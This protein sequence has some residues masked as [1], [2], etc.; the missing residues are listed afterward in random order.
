MTTPALHPTA[1]AV[2]AVDGGNSKADVCLIAA[3]GRLLSS[4]RGP[5]VSHQAVG[6]E[7]GMRRLDEL[8]RQVA[9]E[10]GQDAERGPVAPIGVYALAG[11]DY[12][13]DVR[14]LEAAIG[15]LGATER[16]VV[17]NDCLAALRAGAPRGWG[18]ALI[19]GEGVNAVG[20]APDGRSSGF[21]ALGEISGDWGG[22]YG[23][24]MTGH[25]AAVRAED[26][27][28]APTTLE[29]LV[30][31]HFGCPSPAA[32]VAELYAD[33]ISAD[34]LG[35][36]APIV[37]EAA[38]GGDDVAHAIVARL[39]DE[40]T[41]MAGALARRLDLVDLEVDVV[42]SGGVF[43]T[44]YTPLFD[45]LQAGV[46]RTVPAARIA[47]LT[48]PPVLGAGLLGLD[49]LGIT[50]SITGT[51]EIPSAASFAGTGT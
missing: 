34:R 19:C 10:A 2:L 15:G 40:L 45:L 38:Y 1:P 35:E 48:V 17:V 28:G 33:R 22:G 27:R 11:A 26:G 14:R 8:L 21:P 13:D 51:T 41:A 46:H 49:R 7:E 9:R 30:P 24:G 39:A 20:V 44:G 29:T 43:R 37:F 18:I 23:I 25:I 5:T 47:R 31:R 6:M 3:D 12:P 36:L 4:V 16:T 42:L 32:L 50:A